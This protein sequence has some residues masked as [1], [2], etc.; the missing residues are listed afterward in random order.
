[1]KK[2]NKKLVKKINAK[3][4]EKKEIKKQDK[5]I[6]NKISKVSKTLVTKPSKPSISKMVFAFITNKK[7]L[8]SDNKKAFFVELQDNILK[9]FPK[10]AFKESHFYWY[11]AKYKLQKKY[12]LELTHLQTSKLNQLIHK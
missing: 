4:V 11:I 8:D 12:G 1:M 9:A 10:S 5:K 3:K 2:V 6:V 7:V